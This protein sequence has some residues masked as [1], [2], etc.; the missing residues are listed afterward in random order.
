MY[1]DQM[2]TFLVINTTPED[3][4]FFLEKLKAHNPECPP[5]LIA[6]D[7]LGKDRL[8]LFKSHY[9]FIINSRIIEIFLAK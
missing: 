4:H 1:S 8:A 3:E 9:H 7:V 6:A 5:K 2:A